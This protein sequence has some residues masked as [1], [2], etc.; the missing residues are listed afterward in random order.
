[1]YAFLRTLLCLFFI[2]SV[3]SSK[4]IAADL[5]IGTTSA[6][7]PYVSLN[8]AGDYVGFDIDIA[9]A[10]ASKLERNLVIKDFGSMPALFLALKQ[11]KVDML[12]WAISITPERQKQMEMIYYQ[13]EKVDRLPLLFWDE[14]PADVSTIN[15]LTNRSNTVIAVE[16]GSSQ[17]CFLQSIPGLV[18]KHVD[19]VM[20]AILEIRYAKSLATMVD[21]TLVAGIVKRFPQVKVLD[22]PLPAS[23][24]SFGHGICIDKKNTALIGQVTESIELLR[25][26]GAIAE[27]EKRWNLEER[28]D[29]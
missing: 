5:I 9:K 14:I 23:Q 18:I 13:G 15:D 24:Q 3:V 21:R 27:L 16:A 1:M 4:A 11:G 22:I 10:L 19:K 12:I 20:D 28:K 26:E 7:A 17:D 8:D 29:G 25:S 6:Y 2:G